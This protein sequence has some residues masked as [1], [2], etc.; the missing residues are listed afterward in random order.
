MK[1]DNFLKLSASALLGTTVMPEIWARSIRDQK[2]TSELEKHKIDKC[3]LLEVDFRWP[4]FVGKN[5]RIDDHGQYKKA[6]VLR[7]KTQQGAEGWG[8][9]EEIPQSVL[10]SIL[11]QPLT[12]LI[13]PDTGLHPDLSK[14]FDFAL[15]DLM[16]IVLEKPV[17]ELLG[18]KGS[19][20]NTVYSGMI[21]LDELNADNPSKSIDRVLDNCKWDVDYG[22]RQLKIKIGRSGRWYP[23]EEG[24]KKDIEVVTAIYDMFKD[25]KVALLVDANDMYSLEDSKAFLSGIGNIPLFWFEEPFIENQK[26][27]LAFRKWMDENGFS[28]TFY[29]DG[30]ANPNHEQCMALAK[31]GILNVYLNDIYGF[32][33]TK[34]RRL[35]PELK[36]MDT[37]ASP[38]AWGSLLKTHY[39]AH[40]ASGLGNVV[41]IEGVTCLSENIDFGDYKIKNGKLITSNAPGFGMKLL[42]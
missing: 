22:Y 24:L 4:R 27:S 39:T 17:Y 34:W 31:E 42:V 5:G 10:D 19:R 20:E 33:F 23:H 13:S 3:E 15:H 29:A 6:T 41:T 2:Q 25:K 40:L 36:K 7:L 35:M 18:N 26:E 21:Y 16:G 37:G 30:E 9:S 11:G 8:M 38:H 28:T 1:R 14:A 32:G 12:Q